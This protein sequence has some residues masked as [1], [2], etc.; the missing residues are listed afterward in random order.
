MI[1]VHLMVHRHRTTIF[2]E[3]KETTVHELKKVVE[4]ILKR[5]LEEQQLYKDDQL[6]DDDR[7]TL[8]DCGLS[9]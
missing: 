3:A 6:L 2:T 7:R 5:P 8:L 9:S 1:D 4:G